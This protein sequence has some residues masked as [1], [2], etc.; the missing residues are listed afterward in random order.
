MIGLSFSD[1]NECSRNSDNCEQ[2]CTN[3]LGGFRC[4]CIDGFILQSDNRT[5]QGLRTIDC[6]D[7]KSNIIFFVICNS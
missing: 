1:I 5:C 3:V 2:E 6:N 7:V 4:S